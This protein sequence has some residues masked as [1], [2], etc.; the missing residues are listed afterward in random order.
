M[1]KLMSLVHIIDGISECVGKISSFIIILV[2]GVVIWHVVMRRVY[3]P[4]VLWINELAA[5]ELLLGVYIILGA[6]YTLLTKAHIN[7]DILHR[8]FPLRIRGITDLATSPLFFLFCIALLWKPVM[9]GLKRFLHPLEWPLS[10]IV[11]IG[12]S[13]LLL[14]G[15]SKFIRDLIIAATG[16][17]AA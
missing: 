9:F 13:L 2:I 1:R 14:Q 8:R 15:L 6:A 16:K 11:L 5:C 4:A 10:L 7:V 12:V 17:E 3:F